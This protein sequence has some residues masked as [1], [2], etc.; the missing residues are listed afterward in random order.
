VKT[1]DFT[2]RYVIKRRRDNNYISTLILPP[3]ESKLCN[4]IDDAY[5]FHDAEWL[6]EKLRYYN[7]SDK[8][9]IIPI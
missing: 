5:K 4:S 2:I 1:K 3:E 6:Q 9:D 7:D 8:Y